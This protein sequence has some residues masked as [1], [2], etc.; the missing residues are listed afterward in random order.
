ML[1]ELLHYGDLS[2][3]VDLIPQAMGAIKS[4]LLGFDPCVILFVCY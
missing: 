1:V 4:K 2:G 3:H